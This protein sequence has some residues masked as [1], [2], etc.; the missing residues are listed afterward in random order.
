MICPSCKS[1]LNG[2]LIYETFIS[3]GM[4]PEKALETA[5]MYGAN[6]TTGRWGRQISIYCRDRDRTVEYLC[7]DCGHRWDRT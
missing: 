6:E 3:Q 2:D 4:T 7:P 1:D 5:K